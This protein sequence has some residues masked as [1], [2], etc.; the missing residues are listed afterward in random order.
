M[1]VRPTDDMMPVVSPLPSR[2]GAMQQPPLD[3][4]CAD[5]APS[6]PVLT[7]YDE[8][9]LVTYLRCST[10]IRKVATGARSPGSRRILTR[11]GSLIGHGARLTVTLR[12][13]DG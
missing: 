3:L 11:S 10:P 6:D 4:D 7:S 2:E 1:G 12:A 8:E 5:L 9:H 13:P